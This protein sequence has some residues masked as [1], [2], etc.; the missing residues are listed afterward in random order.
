M[1]DKNR[2]NTHN[3][4]RVFFNNASTSD[5][6][7]LAYPLWSRAA[8]QG[9]VDARVKVG[10]Y[11]YQ[12]RLEL[13][14]KTMDNYYQKAASYYRVAAEQEFSALAMYFLVFKSS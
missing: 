14:N 8:N 7:E 5:V 6:P 9:N 13:Q 1:L 10:D 3:L 4:N 12:G 11:F 2:I